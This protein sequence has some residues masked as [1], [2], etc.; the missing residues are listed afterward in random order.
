[1]HLANGKSVPGE[2][3]GLLWTWWRGDPLPTLPPLPTLTVT[4]TASSHQMATL[5]G[6]SEKEV[7]AMLQEGHR[8]YIAHLNTGPVAYGWSAINRAAFGEGRVKFRVPTTDRYLYYFVTLPPW[9]GMGIYPRLLQA[10]LKH[11]SAGKGEDDPHLV[12]APERFWIV[13]QLSNVASSRGI[14]RAGF[15]I[16][17]KVYFRGD[18]S[19]VLVASAG[20]SRRAR[21]GAE[22]LGLPLLEEMGHP[23]VTN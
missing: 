21:V 12:G 20:E 5:M 9:R 19:L 4:E 3:V 17:S 23:Q 11:E 16:A 18:D 10:I 1:M 14:A 6:I 15:R 8:P 2:Q 22:L 7:A 13:H